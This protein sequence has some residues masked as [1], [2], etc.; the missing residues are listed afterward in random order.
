M[1]RSIV[2]RLMRN[3]RIK[4]RLPNGVPIYLSPDS[5]LKYLKSNFD[6]DLSEMAE[7][8]VTNSSVVWDV[9]ANCGVM[10]FNAAKARQILAIE[11]DPFLAHLIQESVALNGVPVT[12]VAAAAFSHSSLAE[13]SIARRG[14]ASNY[15]TAVGGHT[16]AAGERSRIVV[17]TITLDSLLERFDPPTFIK[18]DVEGAEVEVLEGAKSILSKARPIFYFEAGT[19]TTDRCNQIFASGGYKVTRGTEMN[20]LAEPQ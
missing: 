9:G 6:I 8:F 15:L 18:M 3:R 5:Q 2:E 13:F 17:P 14:R 16:Q 11:A 1:F 12:V 7:K 4:R 20:W 19:A 10:A